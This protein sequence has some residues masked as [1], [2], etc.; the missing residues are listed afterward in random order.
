[1][2]SKL[3]GLVALATFERCF[4]EPGSCLQCAHFSLEV[5]F[6][7]QLFSLLHVIGPFHVVNSSLYEVLQLS[8]CFALDH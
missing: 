1:M 3:L 8:R 5:R 2:L 4:G 7:R 6:L